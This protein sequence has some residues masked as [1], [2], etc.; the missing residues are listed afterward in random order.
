MIWVR[1]I[2]LVNFAFF[3]VYA[4]L[5]ARFV[6]EYVRANEQIRFVQYVHRYTEPL[7]RP[8]RGL[9]PVLPDPGGHP[10]VLSILAAMLAFFVVH[11]VVRGLLRASSRPAL[12]EE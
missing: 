7:Y 1:L 10:L 5:F 12:R 8:F 4:M 2:Q 11:V 6:V 9:L 3:C